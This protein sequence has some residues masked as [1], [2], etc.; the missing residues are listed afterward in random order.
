MALQQEA[1]G[2]DPLGAI[3]VGELKHALATTYAEP[4]C[5]PQ[6]VMPSD[7]LAEL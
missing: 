1:R 3:A 7:L 2:Q 6:N 5:C 4:I